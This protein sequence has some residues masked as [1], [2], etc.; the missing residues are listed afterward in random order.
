[1][2]RA[3]YIMAVIG[4][5]DKE[6]TIRSRESARVLMHVAWLLNSGLPP[7]EIDRSPEMATLWEE[8]GKKWGGT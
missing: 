8:V 4:R 3:E 5:A 1:M 6:G 2:N 7:D